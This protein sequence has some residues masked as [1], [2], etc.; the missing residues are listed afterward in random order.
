MAAPRSNLPVADA[1]AALKQHF[2]SYQGEKYADGWSK[3]WEKGELLPWDRWKPSPALV[4][5]L[6]NY[7][8]IIG[9]PIIDGRRKKALVPGCG[10]GVDVLL[11]QSFGYDAVGL[12]ISSGAVK[13]CLEYAEQHESE[14]PVRDEKVG[15]GS[16]KFV[17]GDFYKSD[18][19]KDAGLAEDGHFELIYDYTV[20]LVPLYRYRCSLKAVLLCHASLYET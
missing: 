15:M 9:G 8:G 18:W 11:L 13:A 20:G 19:L 1:R 14:Y 7:Q 4:D 10:R 5:T 17:Y 6:A 12:E 2:G 3:L 16:R